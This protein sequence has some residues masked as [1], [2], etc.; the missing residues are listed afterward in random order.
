MNGLRL[1]R[2]DTFKSHIYFT[3]VHNVP[4]Y[5]QCVC[6]INKIAEHGVFYAINAI[7]FT[8]TSAAKMFKVVWWMRNKQQLSWLTLMD[9]FHSGA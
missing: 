4:S 5:R 9:A 8:F 6:Y 1:Y 7:L 2:Y 3:V